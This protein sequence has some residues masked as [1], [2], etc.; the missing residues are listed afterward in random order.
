MLS[1]KH[2]SVVLSISIVIFAL[3]VGTSFIGCFDDDDDSFDAACNFIDS[4]TSYHMCLDFSDTEDASESG[5]ENACNEM[6]GTVVAEC[7]SEGL[8]GTCTFSEEGEDFVAYYY[9]DGNVTAELAQNACG[10]LEG[11]WDPN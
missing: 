9:S 7:P 8:L 1:I 6:D 3:I 10:I 4:A 2:L 5:V 11:T